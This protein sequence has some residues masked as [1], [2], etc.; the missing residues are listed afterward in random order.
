MNHKILVLAKSLDGGTGSFVLSLN[1]LRILSKNCKVMILCL[2]ETRHRTIIDQANILYYR[3]KFFYQ[4]N[5]SF[6]LKNII[7][8]FQDFLWLASKIN[9]NKPDIIIGV[10]IYC[11]LLICLYSLINRN[12]RFILTQHINV[13][14]NLEKRASAFLKSILILLVKK[15]YIRANK[16]VFVSRDLRKS[17]IRSFALN[18]SNTYVIYNGIDLNTKAKKTVSKRPRTVIT[19]ARLVKQKDYKTLFRAFKSINNKLSNSCLWV[20]GD[21]YQNIYL[22]RVARE[23][24]IHNRVRFFGW[25][26]NIYSYLRKAHIFIL[27]SRNEGFGI[28]LIEAMSQGLPVISTDTPYGP[29]EILD[30]GK[31]GILVPMKDPQAMASAMYELLTNK[32]KYEHCSKMSLKRAKFFTEEKMLKAYRKIIADVLNNK[33]KYS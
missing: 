20:V 22:E 25:V 11:S 17:F 7:V 33:C 3:K 1:R 12:I 29:R 5:Y 28:V 14:L 32:D 9:T 6:S 13:V 15:L 30:N 10:D 4:E 26:E 24:R 18:E 16:I 2:E 8:Y 19:I 21:G 23:L 31:Y 27:S